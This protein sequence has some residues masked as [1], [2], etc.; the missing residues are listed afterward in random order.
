LEGKRGKVS[1]M[2]EK[3]IFAGKWETVSK[4]KNRHIRKKGKRRFQKKCVACRKGTLVGKEGNFG[5]GEGNFGGHQFVRPQKKETKGEDGPS[6]AAGRAAWGEKRTFQ[7]E[8]ERRR[9]VGEKGTLSASEGKRGAGCLL[10]GKKGMA[11]EG[12]RGSAK[13]GAKEK[14]PP[15]QRRGGPGTKGWDRFP[16]LW[17]GIRHRGG[18]KKEKEKG[19]F[20]PAGKTYHPDLEKGP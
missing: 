12:G 1:R 15:K 14:G 7:L 18:G 13:K 3:V 6:F 2:G 16:F 8:G 5:S 19:G 4:R 9:V 11:R 10:R 20:G 17:K